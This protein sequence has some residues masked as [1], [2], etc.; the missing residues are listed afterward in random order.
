MN[1]LVYKVLFNLTN[2]YQKY[3]VGEKNNNETLFKIL[4]HVFISSEKTKHYQ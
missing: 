1:F 3:C 4:L 2:M